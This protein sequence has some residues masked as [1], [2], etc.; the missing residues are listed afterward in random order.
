M[1][2]RVFALLT[3]SALALTACGNAN[4]EYTVQDTPAIGLAEDGAGISESSNAI[5]M[6]GVD[7][8]NEVYLWTE[9]D[10][11]LPDT[12]DIRVTVSNNTDEEVGMDAERFALWRVRE[13][14]QREKVPYQKGGDG[15][16][17]LGMVIMPHSSGDFIAHIAKHYDL[18]LEEGDYLI[19]ISGMETGFT[20]SADAQ[21]VVPAE[22]LILIRTEHEA[23]PVGV[24][25]IKVLITNDGDEPY[26]CT[27]DQFGLEAFG[28]GFV[29]MTPYAGDAEK[30]QVGMSVP[31]HETGEWTLSVS[32]YHQDSLQAGDYAICMNGKEARFTVSDAADVNTADNSALPEIVFLAERYNFY[33]GTDRVDN[34][35][36]N[37]AF[38][39]RDGGLYTG[40]GQTPDALIAAYKS[41]T[42]EDSFKLQCTVDAAELAAQYAQ[43][44]TAAEIKVVRPQSDPADILTQYLW[45]GVTQNADGVPVL[46]QIC[47][48]DSVTNTT[49]VQ[50]AAENETVNAVGEWLRAQTE[51]WLNLATA[52]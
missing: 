6:E 47:G 42:L 48:A 3:L 35:Q 39:T 11:Y 19:E 21:A 34:P 22:D 26:A 7:L 16:I 13:N 33:V 52:T 44:Q 25:E 41:Q 32:D 14:G 2:K 12:E 9:Q 30:N 17:E 50:Y 20:V 49:G 23:Y 4:N 45:Y 31:P 27:A 8:Y 29:S 10:F 43:L 46:T 51:R 15:F 37:V 38:I 18:P 36:P 1:K 28:D 40:T 24:T 5:Y